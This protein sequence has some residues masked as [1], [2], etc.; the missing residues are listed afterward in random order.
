MEVP[1]DGVGIAL[2]G[3]QLEAAGERLDCGWY[4]TFGL[5][6]GRTVGVQATSR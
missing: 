2:G 1:L 4:F 6:I 3:G 5:A